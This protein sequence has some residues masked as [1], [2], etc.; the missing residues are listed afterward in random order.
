MGVLDSIISGISD[1]GS[2]VMNFLPDM[3]STPGGT[4]GNFLGNLFSNPTFL[5][6][7]LSTGAGLFN[8][9]STIDANKAALD[10][11]QQNDKFNALME[12]AK[13]KYGSKGGG[14]GGTLRNKNADLIE[15][16][17]QGTDEQLKSL[18]AFSQNYTGALK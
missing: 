9:I 15:V 7:A 18:N 3:P 14:G 17:S 12:L 16:L 1:V 6:S 2:T 13:L 5:T 8:S 4:D 11:Q 10:R